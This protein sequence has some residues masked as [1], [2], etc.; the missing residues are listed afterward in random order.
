[1]Q[2]IRHQMMTHL[3]GSEMTAIELSQILGI[4]EKEV[5]SHLPHVSSSVKSKGK[6]LFI[7]PARCLNCRY[8]FKDR[9]RF[10]SPGRCP[11]CRKSHIQMPAYQIR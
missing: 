9:R 11:R 6:R 8:V 10:T 3:N 2:T 1:M 4:P 5:Y 7:Q